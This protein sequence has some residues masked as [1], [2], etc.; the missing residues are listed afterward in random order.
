M[1]TPPKT[2][3][4]SGFDVFLRIAQRGIPWA[5]AGGRAFMAVPA[6]SPGDHTPG[7]VRVIDVFASQF[8]TQNFPPSPQPIAGKWFTPTQ[9]ITT[10]LKFCVTTPPAATATQSRLPRTFSPVRLGAHS[11]Y[12]RRTSLFF[13]SIFSYNLIGPIPWSEGGY[14]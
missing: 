14:P 13:R 12:I 9:E 4:T 10:T 3:G 7:S 6:R 1:H 8:A 11:P 5:A 2:R